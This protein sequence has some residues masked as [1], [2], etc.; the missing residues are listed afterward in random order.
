MRVKDLVPAELQRE[1]EEIRAS[2]GAGGAALPEEFGRADSERFGQSCNHVDRDVSPT[3]L[4]P[5]DV[6]DV[7][8]R[9]IGQLIL[10]PTSP[11]A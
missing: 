1:D 3:A 2:D 7:Q 10:C 11:L 8:A 9:G 6:R 4:D 5:A